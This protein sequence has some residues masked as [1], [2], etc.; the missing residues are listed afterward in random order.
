MIGD[1][2][3]DERTG[4]QN[5][6]SPSSLS[7]LGHMEVQRRDYCHLLL[8][9]Q[10]LGQAALFS[11]LNDY[12]TPSQA[13]AV[14][15]TC[16]YLI[17]FRGAVTMAEVKGRRRFTKLLSLLS[18]GAF[19]RLTTLTCLPLSIP[20]QQQQQVLGPLEARCLASHLSTEASEGVPRG[21]RPTLPN[22]R[23][24]ALVQQELGEGAGAVFDALRVYH[25]W[26]LSLRLD[27]TPVGSS[28]G[29]LAQCLSA[30][31]CLTSLSLNG[32]G[33]TRDDMATLAP[34]LP[35]QCLRELH[36]SNNPFLAVSPLEAP[37]VRGS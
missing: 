14:C 21:V 16:R 34:A 35:A 9:T 18:R 11:L 30:L 32:C 15:Q 20:G 31:Y 13:L 8:L 25:P 10:P 27:G 22:L 17:G 5:I 6:A 19:P 12:L 4:P 23:H 29:R 28:S 3:L 24:L 1:V 33:L 37:R 36:L 7:V 26:L 2:I